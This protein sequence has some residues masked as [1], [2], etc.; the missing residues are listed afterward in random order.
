M[1]GGDGICKYF[2]LIQFYSVLKHACISCVRFIC[3]LIYVVVVNLV[4]SS[5]LMPM[6]KFVVSLYVSLRAKA[7]LFFCCSV[8]S[9]MAT[10]CLVIFVVSYDSQLCITSTIITVIV[11]RLLC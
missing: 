5:S 1:V 2:P 3:I 11:V 10:C 7:G 4:L 8:L 9:C 6:L